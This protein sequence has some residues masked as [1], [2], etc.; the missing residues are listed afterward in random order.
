MFDRTRKRVGHGREREVGDGRKG[1][2]GKKGKYQCTWTAE[3]L[4]KSCM[5][6]SGF[7]PFHQST[8]M[9]RS[10]WS[11]SCGK[12]RQTSETTLLCNLITENY[13][14]LVVY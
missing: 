4:T 11:S 6:M 12:R 7:V 3:F 10:E 8:Y 1:I 2:R 13:Q 5:S 14:T 9:L